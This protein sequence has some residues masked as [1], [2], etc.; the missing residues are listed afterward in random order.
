MV[1]Y[2]CSGNAL[3]MNPS[4]ARRST[5]ASILKA[6]WGI[7]DV[8]ETW[9]SLHGK[10]QDDF[11]WAA[12]NNP[13]GYFSDEQHLSFSQYDAAAQNAIFSEANLTMVALRNMFTISGTA[14]HLERH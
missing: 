4:D 11:L 2:V 7:S 9:S 3:T 14:C 1:N 12:S 13:F 6:A 8:R 10:L 5:F